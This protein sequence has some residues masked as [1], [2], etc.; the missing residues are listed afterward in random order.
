[1]DRILRHPA[2]ATIITVLIIVAGLWGSIFALE[3][4]R[5]FHFY[6]GRGPISWEA[7][8]FWVLVL[9]SASTFFFRERSIASEQERLRKLAEE[10]TGKLEELQRLS[11]ARAD[12]FERLIR[13]LPPE[14]FLEVF[15]TFFGAADHVMD[16][17]FADTAKIRETPDLIEGSVREILRSIAALARRFDGD[18]PLVKH[19]ANV[20]LFRASSDMSPSE[21]AEVRPHLLFCDETVSV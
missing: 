6:W 2:F 9:I 8:V 18:H 1:M 16:V 7:S 13:T 19:A 5:A 4:R 14:N 11:L 17:V 10:R 12:E 20:M 21:M 15:A 3:I